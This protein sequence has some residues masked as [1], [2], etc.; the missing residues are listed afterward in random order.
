ME[1]IISFLQEQLPNPEYF[2][3]EMTGITYPDKNYHIV[4]KHPEIFCLEYIVSGTGYVTCGDESFEPKQGDVYLLPPG[5]IHDYGADSEEPFQKIWMNIKGSLCNHL[6][7]G[8]GLSGHYHFP[9]CALY[10]F[11]KRFLNVCETKQSNGREC[12]E[13]GALLI[14]EIFVALS[15]QL[16]GTTFQEKTPMLKA[17]EYMELK[18]YEKLNIEDLAKEAGMSSSQLTRRFQKEYGTTP[19]KYFLAQKLNT[20]CL[21]LSNTGLQIKE[22]A[23]KLQFADE[24]YFSNIFHEKIGMTPNAYR[25]RKHI[26]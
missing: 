14:H 26:N 22:I 2:A 11:F 19:Y 4:R 18:V 15:N 24:H 10:P 6:Y 7:E 1:H 21:L 17:K 3:I 9:N 8:Y 12:V 23:A 25:Y 20:A 5:V 13:Q 16:S